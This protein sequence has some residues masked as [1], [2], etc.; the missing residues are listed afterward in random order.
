MIA[1]VQM[2]LGLNPTIGS[3]ATLNLKGNLIKEIDEF[4]VEYQALI[5][6]LNSDD[7]L[8]KDIQILCEAIRVE[9]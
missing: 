7:E 1:E 6:K 4:Q 5:A 3:W 8:K 2:N 9:R